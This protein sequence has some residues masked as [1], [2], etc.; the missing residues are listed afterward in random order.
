MK[1]RNYMLLGTTAGIAVALGVHAGTQFFSDRD[2]IADYQREMMYAHH[3]PLEQGDNPAQLA[4]EGMLPLDA[5]HEQGYVDEPGSARPKIQVKYGP[6]PPLPSIYNSTVLVLKKTNQTLKDT[7]D[8]VWNLELMTKDGLVL[9]K[10]PAL[11]GR[12]NRQTANRN[13][14]GTKAPLPKGTYRIERAGIERGPFGDPELGH[15]YWIPVTPLFATGRSDLGFHVDPSWGKLNGESGTSGC[16]GLPDTN[17]TAK[18][19]TWIKHFNVTQ[20]KVES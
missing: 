12:A 6:I 5:T 3:Q 13:Q 19:V 16:I 2:R 18:L 17:A 14:A 8:P 4:P 1:L 7:K 15:G 10:L 11:T 20:L 9:D